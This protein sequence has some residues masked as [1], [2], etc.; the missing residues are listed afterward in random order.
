MSEV[1]DN[2]HRVYSN[3]W[4]GV[5][6]RLQDKNIITDME[7][8]LALGNLMAREFLTIE[9]CIKEIHNEKFKVNDYYRD[10]DGGELHNIL[11]SN[12]TTL[13]RLERGVKLLRTNEFQVQMNENDELNRTEKE[14]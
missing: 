13:I 1:M 3:N 9:K 10:T 6:Q 8:A 2:S 4:R 5:L 11:E 12:T 7:V 14:L